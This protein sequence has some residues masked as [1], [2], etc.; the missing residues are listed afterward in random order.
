MKFV[1]DTHFWHHNIC[2]LSNRP[3]TDVEEMNAALIQNWNQAVAP[4]EKVYHLG[5]FSFGNVIKFEEIIQQLNGYKIIIKGNHDRS[6]A[7]LRELGFDEAYD[8]LELDVDNNRYFLVHNPSDAPKH[9]K[10]RA[11]LHG[12]VHEEWRYA[13]TPEQK[14]YIN[15]GVDVW[16]YEPVTLGRILA[17]QPPYDQ[18]RLVKDMAAEAEEHKNR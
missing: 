16:S 13:R 17:E 7:R 3:W 1:S 14:L 4:D 10:Y 8:S 6:L 2:A 12:H 5:D 18:I 11:V 15:A 9:G